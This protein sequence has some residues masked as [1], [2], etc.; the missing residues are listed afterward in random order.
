M[1]KLCR[2]CK[3]YKPIECFYAHSRMKDG[4]LN[5][6]IECVKTR[7][8]KHRSENIGKIREYDRKRGRTENKKAWAKLNLLK[9]RESKAKYIKNNPV[10]R[11]A[12]TALGNAVRDGRLIKKPCEVCGDV[13]SQ[14]HHD[15]YSKPLEVRWLCAKH[16]KELHRIYKD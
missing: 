14:G 15:D 13:R 4:H 5:K 7:V 6:C 8:R 2:Q 16:H 3:Q 1:D 11:K 9:V 10:K 12:H